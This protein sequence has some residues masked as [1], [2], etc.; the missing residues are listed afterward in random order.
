MRLSGGCQ[1]VSLEVF[2]LLSAVDPNVR[3]AKKLATIR[4]EMVRGGLGSGSLGGDDLELSTALGLSQ[5]FLE[6]SVETVLVI[7]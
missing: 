3:L 2:I 4:V 1:D 6:Q 7:P 5:T